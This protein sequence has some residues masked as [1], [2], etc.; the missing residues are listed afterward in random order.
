MY[1]LNDKVVLKDIY[2]EEYNNK[3]FYIVEMEI[4]NNK[5]ALYK[6][7]SDGFD[8]IWVAEKNFVEEM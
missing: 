1:N 2:F 4:C 8:P 5:T 3:E 6:V 7:K